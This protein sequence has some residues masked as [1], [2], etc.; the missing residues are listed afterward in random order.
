MK[1]TKKYTLLIIFAVFI[2]AG[3]TFLLTVLL[4]TKEP[5]TPIAPK[6]TKASNRTYKKLIV[7]AHIT[8]TDI[9][10]ITQANGD[11]ESQS[12]TQQGETIPTPTEF[13]IVVTP[14]LTGVTESQASLSPTD[15]V[16]GD[17]I[18]QLPEAGIYDFSIIMF[19]ISG[20]ILVFAFII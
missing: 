1:A 14:L 4:Q 15:S 16:G 9:P 7:F 20:A 6:K 12:Q 2:L 5:I 10:L 3:I 17:Q 11:S 19:I 8:P 13:E 18:S